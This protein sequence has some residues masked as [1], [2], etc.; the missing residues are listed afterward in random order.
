MFDINQ[1]YNDITHKRFLC[2]CICKTEEI[3][4]YIESSFIMSVRTYYRFADLY[5]KGNILILD[6]PDLNITK[7]LAV[8]LNNSIQN[9]L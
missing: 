7:Q 3:A 6:T 2:N 4:K 1:I 9:I 8:W 5:V